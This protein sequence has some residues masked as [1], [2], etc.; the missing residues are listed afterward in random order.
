MPG[1]IR[2]GD[3]LDSKYRILRQLG[4]G[5]FGDVYLGDDELLGRQVAIKV[6][7]GRD[8]DQQA[9]LVDEM[10]ALNQLPHSGVVAFYHHFIKDDLLFLVMEYCGGGSLRTPEAAWIAHDQNCKIIHLPPVRG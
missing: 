5:S 4:L 6:L 2:I 3:K 10:Q 1:E 8:P 9:E 7:R